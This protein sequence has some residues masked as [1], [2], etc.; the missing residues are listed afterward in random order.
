MRTLNACLVASFVFSTV[1]RAQ[2]VLVVGPGGYSLPQQAIDAAADGDIVLVKPGA[3]TGATWTISG[4][5]LTLLGDIGTN[6]T[7]GPGWIQNISASQHVTVRGI[8]VQWFVKV[9]S[10]GPVWLED[11]TL[12]ASLTG[13]LPTTDFPML[14]LTNC[15]SV[16]VRGCAVYATVANQ[17]TPAAFL[18]TNSHAYVYSSSFHGAK[19]P[20]FNVG[21]PYLSHGA[22][23]GQIEGGTLFASASSFSGGAGGTF[24]GGGFDPTALGGAGGPGLINHGEVVFQGSGA[25][26]GPGSYGPGGYG[27]NGPAFRGEVPSAIAWTTHVLT[28]S[29]PVREG[30]D[31]VFSFGGPAGERVGMYFSAN[32][33]PGIPEFGFGGVLVVDPL[34]AAPMFLGVLAPPGGLAVH[35]TAPNLPPAV[36]GSTVYAQSYFFDAALTYVTIGPAT[37]VT[38]LDSSL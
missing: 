4:K 38:V 22:P 27:P 17:P 3:A 32:P 10:D 9:Q 19:G 29:S 2:Q 25:S 34:S 7:L 28:N 16:V 11:M 36:M 26:G 30:Q 8:D 15:A 6:P 37:A 35:F 20:E 5:S 1:A 23:G 21:N 12:T 33:I 14:Q 24:V 31:V 18:S 13:P